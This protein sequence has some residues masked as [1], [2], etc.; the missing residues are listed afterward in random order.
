MPITVTVESAQANLYQYLNQ[1]DA[2]TIDKLIAT[3]R[4][5]VNLCQIVTA[6]VYE[7]ADPGGSAGAE[8]DV[9]TA[10][11]GSPGVNTKSLYRMIKKMRDR[12]AGPDAQKGVGT[13]T[14]VAKGNIK[15][16]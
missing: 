15:K 9:V 6:A 4:G 12:Q 5:G 16:V 11:S 2:G 8:V 10:Y 14:A 7:A 3:D 1:L 13:I